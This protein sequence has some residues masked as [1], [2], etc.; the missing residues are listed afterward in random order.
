MAFLDELKRRLLQE[1]GQP[2]PD[3]FVRGPQPTMADRAVAGVVDVP[4]VPTARPQRSAYNSVR[5][6][7]SAPSGP[8]GSFEPAPPHQPITDLGRGSQFDPNTSPTQGLTRDR[9]TQPRDPIAENEDR[10]RQLEDQPVGF[11]KRFGSG[12]LSRALTRRGDETPVAITAR[13]REVQRLQNQLGRGVKLR[14]AQTQADTREAAILRGQAQI[15][16]GADRNRMTQERLDQQRKKD[17]DAQLQ[18]YY[19]AQADFDPDD[20]NEAAF[21]AEW[22]KRFGYKPSKNIRGSQMAVV[23]GY[24]AEGNPIVSIIDKGTAT[25]TRATGAL[26]T[27]TD[28]QLNR[29]QR[30]ELAVT[31]EAGRNK[32]AAASQVGANQRAGMRGQGAGRG[33]ITDKT[34]LR[35]AAQLTGDIEAVR[36]ELEAYDARNLGQRTPENEAARKLI[37]D[38]A[39]AA[40]TELNNLGVGYEAG[41]GERGYPYYKQ[42]GAG[43]GGSEDPKVRAYA[44]KFFNGDVKAAEAAIKQQ[45]GQ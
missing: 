3:K 13:E 37:A 44:D 16:Q 12:L 26:P 1:Q 32:R 4:L 43:G 38:K 45:R 10:L 20:P 22:Q 25:A 7:V 34:A 9:R 21:V 17:T 28:P 41:M 8:I 11:W 27:T 33:V 31:A 2:A 42:V 5:Q 15:D 29:K 39:A 18:R 24:D 30:G 23:S 6:A 40:M 35:K 36:K 14:A 19:N